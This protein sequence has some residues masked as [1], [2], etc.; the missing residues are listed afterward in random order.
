MASLL[1]YGVG[2]FLNAIRLRI[3]VKVLFGDGSVAQVLLSAGQ[4]TSPGGNGSGSYQS[5]S[6]GLVSI[7]LCRIEV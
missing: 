4:T 3:N 6:W 2:L 1:G 7:P 5:I